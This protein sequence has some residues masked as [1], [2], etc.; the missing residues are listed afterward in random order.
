MSLGEI[1]TDAVKYP[2]SDITKFLIVGVLSV[3]AGLNSIVYP[4]GDG[5]AVISL[6]LVL[7]SL[8]FALILSGY[9]VNV[10]KNAI[11]NSSAIPDVDPVA[12]LVDGIKVIIIGI[13]YFIIPLIIAFIFGGLTSFV[14]A[15][16]N[17]AGAGIGIGVIVSFIVFI[18]FAIFETVAVSRFADSGE[19]GAAFNFGAVIE[20]AKRIGFLNIILYVI[21]AVI[22]LLII[23]FIV[24][25]LAI[26]PF[27]GVLIATIILGG[28]FT[29]FYYRGIGLLYASA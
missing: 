8:I 10:I 16:L 7:I 19:L 15:G 18:I 28:F 6:I 14:G 13:V 4:N 20:D 12:N 17:H 1:I 25:L 23:S 2:F 3:L 24:G 5:N 29:L 21:V 27:I 9:S 11:Q 26:I 22:I